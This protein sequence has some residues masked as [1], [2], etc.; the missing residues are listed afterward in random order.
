MFDRRSLHIALLLWG[1]IF[2]LLTAL[3]MLL[4][5][6]FDRKK[7]KWII[8]MEVSCAFLLLCDAM[9]WGFRGGEGKI[10]YVMVRVSNFF[11]FALSDVLLYLFHG[12]V[13]CYLFGHKKKE[14]ASKINRD[15]IQPAFR[16][17]AVYIIAITGVILS[18]VSQFTHL[19]YRIDADNYSH[20]NPAYIISLLLPLTGMV[21]DLSLLTE[22]RKKISRQIF[23]SM[24]SY[25]ALPLAAALIT[26]FYYG[27]SLINLAICIS[28]ILMFVAAMAE[29]NQSLAAREKEA[30]DLRISLMLSQIAPHF[31]YN[32]LNSI[33]NMCDTNPAMAK[34]TLG[35]FAEYLR[36]NLDAL[37]E[38]GMVPFEQELNHIKCYLSIEKKRFGNRLQV[39]YDIQDTDFLLPAL[40]VQ[41]LVENAVKHGICKKEEG[42]IVKISTERGDGNVIVRVTDNG[43]GF[44]Q[45]SE[46]CDG[47]AHVGLKNVENRLK[48]MCN[49]TMTV[50]SEIGTGTEV[51]IILPQNKE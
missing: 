43:T 26:A 25:I 7:R 48:N 29:Q 44:R 12:Y 11:V 46:I 18:V 1:C 8:S 24:L 37:S 13:C 20:R 28:M 33:Q 4:S 31:I 16:I 17:K 27:I 15:G 34:E 47:H 49:G 35:E 30:A 38:K 41:P 3:C 50:S 14:N 2:C 45:N 23:I 42:G 32:T 39:A 21:L 10:A 6:N 40:T 22:Y 19:Y 51:V 9:A 5:R 36:G